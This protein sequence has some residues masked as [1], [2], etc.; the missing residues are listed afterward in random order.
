MVPLDVESGFIAAAVAA[1][2][3]LDERGLKKRL[4]ALEGSIVAQS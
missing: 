1:A 2:A 4:S 3:I